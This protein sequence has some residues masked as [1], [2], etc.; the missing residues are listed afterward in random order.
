MKAQKFTKETINEFGVVKRNFAKFNVGDTIAVSQ[1]IKEGDKERIQVFQGDVIAIR[2]NK[3]SSTFT[4]RKIGANSI[5]VERIFPYYSPLVEDIKLV[6]VGKVRR[7]KLFY[8]REK[9]GKSSKLKEKILTR[10]QK[11]QKALAH[12]AELEVLPQVSENIAS[13]DSTPAA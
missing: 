8:I 10:E 2:N 6:R 13:V 12:E 7:A 1:R 11:D 5:A 3:I 9:V 4:V